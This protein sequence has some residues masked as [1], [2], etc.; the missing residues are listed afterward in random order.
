MMRD[1]SNSRVAPFPA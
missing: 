1:R